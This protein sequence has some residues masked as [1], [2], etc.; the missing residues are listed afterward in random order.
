MAR[1]D[2]VQLSDFGIARVLEQNTNLTH[3]GSAFFGTPHY[4]APEQSLGEIS[5]KSDQ[6]ALGCIAYELC[7]GRRFKDA[8]SLA[9]SQQRPRPPRQ[10]NPALSTQADRAILRAV[11]VNPDLRYDAVEAFVA[12]FDIP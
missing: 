12:A 10:F 6:Y 1:P 8:S 9:S 5:E 3:S 11:S 4:M 2:W 7:T